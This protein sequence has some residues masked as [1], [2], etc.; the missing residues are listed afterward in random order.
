MN[1]HLTPLLY[2]LSS[3]IES[4][5][6]S[7]SDLQDKMFKTTDRD[8]LNKETYQVMAKAYDDQ[9]VSM[10]ELYLELI[11]TFNQIKNAKCIH[12]NKYLNDSI[13]YYYENINNILT[14]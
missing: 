5:L 4:I 6:N 14:K 2:A 11:C 8:G 1:A 9:V 13:E 3:K 7:C 12:F 10:I